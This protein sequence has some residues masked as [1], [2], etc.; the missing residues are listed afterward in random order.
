MDPAIAAELPLWIQIA[1]LLG[2]GL[3]LRQAETAGL[4]V[5]RIDWLSTSMATS[6][7]AM[8]TASARR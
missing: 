6:G 4:T 2:A 8:T 1:A 3:G 5:D 7:P